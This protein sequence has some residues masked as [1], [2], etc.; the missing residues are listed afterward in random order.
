MQNMSKTK[1]AFKSLKTASKTKWLF[2]S[3][4]LM[5][6]LTTWQCANM[7][8]PTGGPIDSIAP[9]I[10]KEFPPNLTKNFKEEKIVIE[11]D[12][13]VKLNNYQQQ[14]SISPDMDEFPRMRTRKKTLEIILPDSIAE[15]TTYMIN[16]GE[17]LVDYNESNPL[18]EYSYIF[19]TGDQIDSLEIS[20]RV[21]DAYNN[22]HDSTSK[23]LLIPI[24]QDSTFGKKKA[25]IFTTVDSAGNF[26]LKYLSE[27]TYRIYALREQN[28]NR[29]YDAA[30]EL[31]G[32]IPDSIH[33]TKDTSGIILKTSKHIPEKLRVLNRTLDPS[34]RITIVL[35][36]TLENPIIKIVDPATEDPNKIIDFSSKKDSITLHLEK[37][38]YDSIKFHIFDGTE[39]LDSTLIR[40]S[41]SD[42]YDRS[43][44]IFE[45]LRSGKVD[46]IKHLELF[47]TV[48]I[49]QIDKSKFKLTEDSIPRTNFQLVKDSINAKKFIIR[50][51]WKPK[52]TY[53]LTIEKG[54]FLGPFSIENKPYEFSFT[55]DD[56]NPY[57][58]LELNL[59]VPDTTKN[60]IV[61]FIAETGDF[62]HNEVRIQQNTTISYKKYYEGKYRLR[63]IYDSNNNGKWDTGNLKTKTQPES[64]WYF[65]KNFII[66]PNWEQQ[67]VIQIP[68]ER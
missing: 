22:T 48:L 13:F 29:I 62:V 20:G 68:E 45:K 4:I 50:Y 43:F 52:L 14:M 12:E 41:G 56:N 39:L 54:A 44:L 16:F 51:N 65:P 7:Q 3:Y 11:F 10:I 66:R 28:N 19:S 1:K 31:L 15:N 58:D 21:I 17:G 6:M 63:V 9:T 35:N 37:H 36:K 5:L 32:F 2:L 26:K 55:L 33:L 40:R 25:N 23:V 30:D 18:K 24:S 38:E 61:Q 57:G 53:K 8:Q 27:N 46:R 59:Q 34:G 49:N 67:E 47:S 64:V 60:Y 42:E